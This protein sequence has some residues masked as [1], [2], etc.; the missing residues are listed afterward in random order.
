MIWDQNSKKIPQLQIKK[1]KEKSLSE[2][3]IELGTSG[4]AG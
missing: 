3:G 4:T 2:P 1:E